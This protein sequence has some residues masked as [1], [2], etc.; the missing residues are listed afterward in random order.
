MTTLQLTS[1]DFEQVGEY[2]EYIGKEDLTNFEGNLEVKSNLGRLKF[3]RIKVSGYIWIETGNWIETD[4]SIKSGDSITVGGSIETGGSI[5]TNSW[6]ETDGSIIAGGSIEA[7]GWIK[8]SRSIEAG[9]S[10]EAV[11]WIEAGGSIEAVDWIEAGGLIEAG[12]SIKA[13]TGGI[14]AGQQV[15]CKGLLKFKLRL[16]A[17]T[18]PHTWH[19]NCSKEVR[20]G[21]L[22]GN[23]VYGDVIE[24]GLP[25]EVETKASETETIVLNGKTYKLV[26][27]K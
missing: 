11:G 13:E 1:K 23:V 21:K 12:G 8:A 14:L 20:C 4:G 3:T 19:K 15:T 10:I 17:G 7:G 26:E 18:S 5:R 22:V 2:K 6:I 16:F 27:G 25:Y 24:T 9:G